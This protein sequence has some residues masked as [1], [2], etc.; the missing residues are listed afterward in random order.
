M[1]ARRGS[2]PLVSEQLPGIR[3]VRRIERSLPPGTFIDLYLDRFERRTVVQNKSENLIAAARFSH[4]G[5]RRF[6][7]HVGDFGLQPLSARIRILAR[8]ADAD[9]RPVPPRLEISKV[10][11]LLKVD[12]RKPLHVSDAVP[13]GHDQAQ[14]RAL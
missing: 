3:G 13:A 4:A 8:P 14:R 7:V 1:R 12:L 6:Q 11:V 5:D 10:A 9:Y 2:V